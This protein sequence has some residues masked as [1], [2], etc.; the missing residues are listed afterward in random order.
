[1]A[2]P[3]AQRPKGTRDF[4]PEEMERRRAVETT[5]RGIAQRFGYREVA[6]PTFEHLELFTSKSG[7]GVVKQLYAFKDKAGRDLTLRPELTAPV[8]RFY[9]NEMSTL[10]KPLKLFYFGNCFRYEEPQ[11]GRY[12]EFWQFGTEL[13]G[14]ETPEAAAESVALAHALLTGAG[15][16]SLELRVGHIGVLKSIARALGLD[17]K[18][19]QALFAI[20]DKRQW[21]QEEEKARA[22]LGRSQA[23]P[24]TERWV[25]LLADL[26]TGE[27]TRASVAAAHGAFIAKHPELQA[28]LDALGATFAFLEALGVRGAHEDLGVV[29]GLD[30]YT[31]VVFEFHSPDLGAESQVCGGGVYALAELFGGEP[32]GSTGFAIGFDRALLALDRAGL[33]SPGRQE[34]SAFIAPIGEGARLRALALAAELRASGLAVDIDLMRRG[35]SKC[36]DYANAIGARR[37]VLLGSKE[38]E[39]GVATVKDMA[40]GQQREVPLTGLAEA[41]RA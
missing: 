13:V 39:R 41:L 16:R 18:D 2:K 14:P 19:R 12:R 36:L 1:M 24:D 26:A 37:V 6:T 23:G 21:A 34:L 38:L 20:I 33:T 27:A 29:R 8:L 10:P 35:P 11:S 4:R 25:A 31:G 22:I 5:F 17:D 7:E 30:Y 15:L 32:V 28:A 40:S 3:G 9:V